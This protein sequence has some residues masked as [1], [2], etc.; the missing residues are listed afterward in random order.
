MFYENEPVYITEHL[1]GEQFTAYW[2]Y[3]APKGF[4][5]KIKDIIGLYDAWKLFSSN[6]PIA[7]KYNLKD[8]LMKGLRIFGVIGTDD[9]LYI[10]DIYDMNTGKYLDYYRDSY[11]IGNEN[12]GNDT[13][14]FPVVCYGMEIDRVPEIYVGS[15]NK[16]L[17]NNFLSIYKSLIVKPMIEKET[18]AGRKILVLNDKAE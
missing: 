11:S 12:I 1:F 8:K 6:N 4:W 7:E 5:E 3:H 9:T 17:V 15:Y 10:D 14:L 2:L 18:P 16:K 13:P